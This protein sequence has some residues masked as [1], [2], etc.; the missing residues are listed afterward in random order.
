MI[1]LSDNIQHLMFFCFLLVG[2]QP[3]R[4]YRNNSFITFLNESLFGFGPL[5]NL[6]TFLSL[7]PQPR[8]SEVQTFRDI[9]STVL[10]LNVDYVILTDVLFM[11][12]SL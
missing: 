1:Y 10:M 12:F 5:P 4:C 8:R 11:Y 7:M 9:N 6:T 2:S 3:L